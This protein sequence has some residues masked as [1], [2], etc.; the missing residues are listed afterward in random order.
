MDTEFK[1]GLGDRIAIAGIIG[2]FAGTVAAMALPLAYPDLAPWIWR[3]I[4]WPSLT[5]LVATIVFLVTDLVIRPRMRGWLPHV[6]PRVAIAL[7]FLCALSSGIYWYIGYRSEPK[8][9]KGEGPTAAAIPRET[10]ED[11]AGAHT[12]FP[13]LGKE[14]G[15]IKLSLD[16][17]I[18]IHDRAIVVW[19]QD[20]FTIFILSSDI[21][22][23]KVTRY[24]GSDRP[25]DPKWYDEAR[26]RAEFKPPRGKYP[27]FGGIAKDWDKW[28][29]IGWRQWH[30]TLKPDLTFYREF[31]NGVVVGTLPDD[32]AHNDGRL[33]IIFKDD[34]Y[35]Q[36]YA[37]AKAPFCAQP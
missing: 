5:V 26:L 18:A 28:K 10:S 27:P 8:D 22:Q 29:W 12:S 7:L 24:H 34:S 17:Y 25:I 11:L 16:T 21:G 35:Q 6:R 31:E 15:P 19:L 4:F 14:L 1:L 37:A 13:A 33:F 32:V 9:P 30:C 2:G 20:L 36:R 3:L 23:Q